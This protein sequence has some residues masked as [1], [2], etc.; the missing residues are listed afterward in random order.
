MNTNKANAGVLT[1]NGEK[2]HFEKLDITYDV[3]EVINE[4][5]KMKFPFYKGILKIF[6]GSTL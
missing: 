3:D 2:V 1:I 6:Y 5:K 4:I